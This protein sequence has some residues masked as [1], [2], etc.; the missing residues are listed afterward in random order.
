MIYSTC[1]GSIGY[2]GIKIDVL[3]SALQKYGRRREL[4]KMLWCASEIYLF[5]ALAITDKDKLT[6]KAIITNMINRLKIIIEEEMLFS[7]YSNNILCNRW[8]DL[9]DKNR[10]MFAYI[11][12][13]C[14]SIV[15][16]KML[17]LNSDIMSYWYRRVSNKLVAPPKD[18]INDLLETDKIYIDNEINKLSLPALNYEHDNILRNFIFCIN[19]NNAECYYWAHKLFYNNDKLNFSIFKRKDAIYILW[20]YLLIKSETNKLMTEI[21]NYK[22]KEF[23]VKN[24][25]ERHMWLSGAVSTVLHSSKIEWKEI[26]ED[27]YFVSEDDVL[28]LFTKRSTLKL[29]DY[30]LDMHCSE[31][32]KRK[33]DKENF[34][35]EGSL[36]IGEDKEYFMEEWRKCYND[37][38]ILQSKTSKKNIESDLPFIK[39]SSDDIQNIELMTENTCGGKV[40]CFKYKDMIY[41]EGRKSMNYNRDY[42]CIDKCKKIFGLNEI[43]MERVQCNFRIV[44]SKKEGTWKNNWH[45]IW[46]PDGVIYVKMNMIGSGTMLQNK[47]HLLDPKT[48]KGLNYLKEVFKIAVFRGIFQATDFHLR[49]ILLD[50]NNNL[51]SIDENDIGKRKEILDSRSA[52]LKN[53]IADANITE[54]VLNDIK[55]DMEGKSQIIRYNM[56]KYGFSEKYICMILKNYRDLVAK[57]II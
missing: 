31:G 19:S 29:D 52:W 22:L 50:E 39:L 20:K 48:E 40:M 35:L 56:Q 27:I 43:G 34:A 16:S 3:K 18:N 25:K 57:N 47:K 13:V 44:K 46:E 51:V 24:R 42:I 17:R 32:R 5:H 41:K 7:D 15:N 33:K 26:N 8:L 53:M 30:V 55:Y 37:E 36:I 11:M 2:S 14:K 4:D 1:Y 12:L 6:A 49:N 21:L 23:F 9:F 10:N 28:K 45:V 54:E 38:K